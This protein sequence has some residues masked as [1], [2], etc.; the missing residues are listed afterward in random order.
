MWNMA[1]RRRRSCWAGPLSF[2]TVEGA[3]MVIISA[4]VIMN[5]IFGAIAFVI[6]YRAHG[7][8]RPPAVPIRM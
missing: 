1:Q 5:V 2:R 4:G 7:V 8:D 3:R 6:V